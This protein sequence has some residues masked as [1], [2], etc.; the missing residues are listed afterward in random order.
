MP[1]TPTLE[2][3]RHGVGDEASI[4]C[5][6]HWVDNGQVW[7][8]LT[9]RMEQHSTDVTPAHWSD[10]CRNKPTNHAERSQAA[11]INPPKKHWPFSAKREKTLP[12]ADSSSWPAARSKAN[13]RRRRSGHSR[14]HRIFQIC[15]LE[16]PRKSWARSGAARCHVMANLCRDLPSPGETRS[17]EDPQTHSHGL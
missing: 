17:Q 3:M 1:E 14:E 15:R 8:E 9:C 12:G 11:G 6:F 5:G 2:A 7:L 16:A 4:S 13:W 10:K